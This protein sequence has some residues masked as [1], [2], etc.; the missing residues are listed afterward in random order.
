MLLKPM[1]AL[2][3]LF[4]WNRL[5]M[6]DVLANSYR[7]YHAKGLDYICLQRKPF[8]TI[9]AYFFED[10]MAELPEVVCPHDH[11]Y[12]FTTECVSGAVLNKWY[13]TETR[14]GP[15]QHFFEYNWDTPLNGGGGFSGGQPAWLWGDGQI[16]YT[17]GQMYRMTYQ[18]IH[19]L[20]VL[21]PQTCI[22]VFQ[23]TTLNDGPTRTFCAGDPPPIND[24]YNRFTADQ[25][26]KRISL[27][28]ELYA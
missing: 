12:D 8:L 22:V 21:E 5:D 18:Q 24:L 20:Q 25:V 23:Y 17:P 27:L 9:K 15:A 28:R 10:R 14:L 7:D 1:S 4:D 13:T 6:E 2:L 3:D 16:T 26:V 19:T 11:R